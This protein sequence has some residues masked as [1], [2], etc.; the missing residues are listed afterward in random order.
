MEHKKKSGQS[1]KFTSIVII[2]NPNSTGN[3]RQNALQLKRRLAKAIKPAIVSVVA[4]NHAG[5]AED[6][7]YRRALA[8]AR[9]LIVASSGDG[10]YHEVVNG[11][12]RA[13]DRG[14][15]VATGLLPSGNAND[16]WH[17]L[18]QGDIMPAIV[19][20]RTRHI[21]VM[22]LSA[23]KDGRTIS[24]FAHSYIGLGITPLVGAELNKVT[25]GPLKEL[26]IVAR[27][28]LHPASVKIEVGGKR[29][30]YTNLILSN[31]LKMSKVLTLADDA[32]LTDGKFEVNF[33]NGQSR[34]GLYGHLLKA[35]ASSLDS[36]THVRTYQFRTLKAT[37]LQLDG[38]IMRL[39]PNTNVSVKC[40]QK[41]LR[42]IV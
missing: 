34:F 12:L 16:H 1:R 8:S 40:R 2:Y 24:R 26:W 39:A 3:G 14:A 20:G 36:Q 10:G 38:E 28:L 25:L 9:V 11:A 41:Y 23:T 19:K 15:C 6:I 21:D 35:A 31:V 33:Y 18:H 4:T 22:H 27:T 30:S 5:H 29:T 37:S 32:S 7:A 17:A 42:C 13:Q